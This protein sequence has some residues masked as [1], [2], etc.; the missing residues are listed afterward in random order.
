MPQDP[1]EKLEILNSLITECIER[2]AQLKRTKITRPP[3]PWLNREDIRSLQAKRN[4]LHH[5]AHTTKSS[6]LWQTFR[7]VR[8]LIKIKIKEAKQSFIEKA[9][10]STKP[11][12]IWHIIYQIIKPN[13]KPVRLNMNKLNKHFASTTKRTTGITETYSRDDLFSFVDTLET[14]SIE[15]EPFTR[16][17]VTHIEVL[18]EILKFRS[19]TSTGP[20]LI[21]VKF[22]KPV[23]KYITSPLTHIINSFIKTNSFSDVWKLARISPIPKTDNPVNEHDMRPISILPALSTVYE[24]LVHHQVIEYINSR[25]LLKDNISGFRKGHSTTT[26]LLGI[27][28]DIIRVMKRGE[29]TLMIM[30]DF[31]KAFDTIKYKTVLRKLNLLGFS[32]AYLRWTINYLTG[33]SQFVQ[34]DDRTSDIRVIDFGVPQGSIMGLLIFNLYVADLQSLVASKCRQYADDSTLYEHFKPTTFQNCVSTLGTS[35]QKLKKWSADANLAI[36]PTKTKLMLV[37]TKQLSSA[38][39]LKDVHL[40]QGVNRTVIERVSTTKLLGTHISQHLKWEDN[41]Y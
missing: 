2:H 8:N 39:S 24:R 10:S 38:H 11:K 32:K 16:H 27:R 36:N 30:A 33:R 25:D 7:D 35:L 31:S 5:M 15:E 4:T 28:D 41:V 37:S 14:E 29:I 17:L 12:E 13:P 9:L 26:A 18:N 22:I 20:D 3:A 23:A 21:P 6:D 19:D 1:D 40:D 34:I